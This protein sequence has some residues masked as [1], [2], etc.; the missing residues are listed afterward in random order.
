MSFFV[1]YPFIKQMDKQDLQAEIQ[2]T[3]DLE[4]ERLVR[5]VL[6]MDEK[7]LESVFSNYHLCRNS[8]IYVHR[9]YS[10]G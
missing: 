2:E 5:E 9:C 1:Y 10:I 4:D 6:K 8:K 7:V 3:S